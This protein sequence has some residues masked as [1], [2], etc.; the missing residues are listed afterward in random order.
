MWLAISLRC[1]LTQLENRQ[2]LGIS[3]GVRPSAQRCVGERQSPSN[4]GMAINIALCQCRAEAC[5]T[6]FVQSHPHRS[7]LRSMPYVAMT[8]CR[9]SVTIICRLTK[10][11]GDSET[12]LT[13]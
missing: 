2:G 1:H 8:T 5:S 7:M 4:C 6:R 10:I 11:Q 12:A 3:L 9:H 13:P